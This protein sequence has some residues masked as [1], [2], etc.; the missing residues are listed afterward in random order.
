MNS[1][2]QSTHII[3]FVYQSPTAVVVLYK[4]YDF[5]TKILTH[6]QMC[7]VVSTC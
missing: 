4:L 3:T 5:L 2:N 7:Q 1:F 6:Q